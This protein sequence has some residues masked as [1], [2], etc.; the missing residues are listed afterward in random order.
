MAVAFRDNLMQ[1]RIGGSLLSGETRKFGAIFS[2]M[3][4]AAADV[5]RS[6]SQTWWELPHAQT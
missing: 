6:H 4:A 5:C 2:T 1:R 3:P